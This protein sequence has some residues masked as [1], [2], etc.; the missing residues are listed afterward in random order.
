MENYLS[1]TYLSSIDIDQ[2][3]RV[4]DDH[5]KR[6]KNVSYQAYIRLVKKMLEQE[7]MRRLT[8]I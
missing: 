5:E 1:E 2:F 4:L 6:E 8:P 3:M 7:R